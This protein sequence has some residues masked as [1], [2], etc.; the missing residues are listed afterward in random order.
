MGRKKR[1]YEDQ[2]RADQQEYYDFLH[3]NQYKLKL[4]KRTDADVISW[5]ES[6]M[7]WRSGTSFQGEIRRLI[8][9]E[10]RRTNNGQ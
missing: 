6:K 7:H 9:E 8:R 4:N 1:T 5:I 2:R 10:I 3:T